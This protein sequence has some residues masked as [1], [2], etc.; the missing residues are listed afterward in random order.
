MNNNIKNRINDLYNEVHQ[1]P[2]DVHNYYHHN[3]PR[4]LN[5][6][7]TKKQAV[8][9][10]LENQLV[11]FER[12]QTTLNKI[13]TAQN[14]VINRIYDFGMKLTKGYNAENDPHLRI[15]EK[16]KR[17]RKIARQNIHVY[18]NA[19]QEERDNRIVRFDNSSD[20]MIALR[21]SIRNMETLQ[22]HNGVDIFR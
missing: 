18:N 12:A 13:T 4:P 15:A 17:I 19:S 7:T 21:N 20:F 3:G 14:I 22:R 5:I 2:R 10:D 1:Y 9:Q 16:I 11:A 8:Q 6:P